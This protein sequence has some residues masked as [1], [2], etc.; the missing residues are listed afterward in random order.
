[1]LLVPV[2]PLLPQPSIPTMNK[3]LQLTALG[4]QGINTTPWS[5]PAA[6]EIELKGWQQSEAT[7]LAPHAL[8]LS[9]PAEIRYRIYECAL[10]S[11]VELHYR[12][13]HPSL[14]SSIYKE[15]FDDGTFAAQPFNQLKNTCQR[16]K[17]ETTEL[18]LNYNRIVVAPDHFRGHDYRVYHQCDDVEM[19]H[20]TAQA[21]L[22]SMLLY[23]EPSRASWLREIT[24][25]Q[26]STCL[27]ACL[28]LTK[29][30]LADPFF[31]E[32]SIGGSIA[33]FDQLCGRHPRLVFRYRGP[34]YH[35]AHA[36]YLLEDVLL[37]GVFMTKALRGRNLSA[38]VPQRFHHILGVLEVQISPDTRVQASNL[39]L[40]AFD[41]DFV[42]NIE[43]VIAQLCQSSTMTQAEVAPVLQYVRDWA[44]IGI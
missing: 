41:D 3:L 20:V 19:K 14:S 32:H 35:Y 30:D 6:E 2:D 17:A 18:E 43:D 31:V 38:L 22:E 33:D 26:T 40:S 36:E 44:L 13:S 1:M 5:A 28:H 27:T 24:I 9:L 21:R 39:V 7:R 15:R 29:N 34:L 8:L 25:D 37:F 12:S 16:L 4:M 42:E 23:L 11:P 10:T